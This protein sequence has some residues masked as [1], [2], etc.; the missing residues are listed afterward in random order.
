MANEKMD[1]LTRTEEDISKNAARRLRREGFIPAVVY[2]LKEEPL[3]IKIELKKFKD[4]LKDKS[5]SNL[6]L[7][8]QVKDEK[9]A[10]NETVLIKDVQRDPISREFIHLDFFRIEMKKEV[11]TTVPISIINEDIAPGIKEEGGVLQYENREIHIACLPMDI[12]EFIEYDVKDLNMG[13]AVRV[14]DLEVDNK[15]KILNE[16]DDLVVSI[17]PP[18]HLVEEEEEAEEEELVEG[19]EPEVIGREEEKPEG[20]AGEEK[21][22]EQEKDSENK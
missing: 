13:D 15:V 21:A 19:E 16:P 14:S 3:N 20:E 10:K 17:I 9:K 8:L 6:I 22:P 2:G 7:D 5:L 1:I 18:T 4:I 12:P 11:E